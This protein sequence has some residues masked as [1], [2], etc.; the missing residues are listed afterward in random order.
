[1]SGKKMLIIAAVLALLATVAAFVAMKTKI[2]TYKTN[3]VTEIVVVAKE[4]IPAKTRLNE[5]MVEIVEVPKEFILD[6]VIRDV[7]D[8]VDNIT[9]TDIYPGEQ[10]LRHNFIAEK[11]SSKGLSYVVPEGLRAVSIGVNEVTGVA[12]LLKAG[13]K[14]DVMG[15]MDLEEGLGS[16]A[17]KRVTVTTVLAQNIEVLAVGQSLANSPED[18]DKKEDKDTLAVTLAVPMAKALGIVQVDEKG[19]LRLLLRSPVDE[20][21]YQGKPYLPNELLKP[22]RP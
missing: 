21:K 13:D 22:I 17:K 6:G 2:D 9:V 10:V 1:M 14:V 20:S 5:N 7:S 18:E 12:G 8:V 4:R 3:A 15:T 19:K 16:A 11:D